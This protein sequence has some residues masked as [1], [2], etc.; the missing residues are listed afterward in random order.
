MST[1]MQSCSTGKTHDATSADDKKRGLNAVSL[2]I[3]SRIIRVSDNSKHQMKLDHYGFAYSLQINLSSQSSLI[4]HT[5]LC[6]AN[7]SPLHEVAQHINFT[8]M[9]HELDIFRLV[10]QQSWHS[11]PSL[12]EAMLRV[13]PVFTNSQWGQSPSP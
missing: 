9:H 12:D 3:R 13:N 7:E 2:Y 11:L 8:F 10:P 5:F 1:D 6:I 4:R